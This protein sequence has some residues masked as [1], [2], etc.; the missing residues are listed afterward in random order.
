MNGFA[1]VL[2]DMDGTLIY[3]K[4]VI[5]RCLNQT[6]AQ[7]GFEPFDPNEIYNLVGKP[8]REV[9]ALKTPDWQP[10]VSHYRQLYLDT[11]LD[12]THL[13]D[14]MVSILSTLKKEGKKIGIV[15]L[16]QTHV[17][18]EVLK[19]L[20]IHEY[21]DYVEGDDDASPL[22]P[23]PLQIVRVCEAMNVK[24]EESV[25]IGDSAMDIAAGKG[26]Q[27][28]TIGVL[29]GSS[30]MDVL[31]DAEVDFLARNPDELAELLKKL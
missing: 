21:V 6:L 13:H 7:F 19:G 25:M 9:L 24:P 17:A 20:K 11:F 23:S 5:S 15:T 8:L 22:K 12:G 3:S 28:I 16:K 14:G 31:S 2:F 26:A 29:W 18:R 27:C 10:M 30:S 1:A 4:G